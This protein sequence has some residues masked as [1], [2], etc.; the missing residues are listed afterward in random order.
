[1]SPPASNADPKLKAAEAWKRFRF[2]GLSDRLLT[3]ARNT[4]VLSALATAA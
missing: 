3:E 1:M 2:A 4:F